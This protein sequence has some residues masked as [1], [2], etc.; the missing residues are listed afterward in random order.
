M[1]ARACR[2]FSWISGCC[3]GKLIARGLGANPISG[4]TLSECKGHSRSSQRISGYSRAVLGIQ[5][6][7]L[8]MRNSILGMASHDL[9]N[10]KTT[11][12]GATPGEFMGTHMKDL[13]SP[14]HSRSFFSRIGVVPARKKLLAAERPADQT[15]E[16][17]PRIVPS[18]LGSSP[19]PALHLVVRI[20]ELHYRSFLPS[21][22]P[23]N[24]LSNEP[25][26]I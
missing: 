17:K 19:S 18:S 14:L 13:H 3:S 21:I 9:S 23:R 16:A 7:I 8:G 1:G 12:I 11:I 25:R 22:H 6:V 15:L 5:K 24:L 26:T 10:T 4:K 2:V 20:A